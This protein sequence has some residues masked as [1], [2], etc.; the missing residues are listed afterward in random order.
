MSLE[1]RKQDLQA[2]K[3]LIY[4]IEENRTR[5]LLRNKK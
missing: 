1:K 5:A 4:E 3:D 2:F